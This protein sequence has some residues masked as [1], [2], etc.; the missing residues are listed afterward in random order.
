[1]QTR[2]T[3]GT[4]LGLRV[5]CLFCLFVCMSVR[6]FVCLSVCLFVCSLPFLGNDRPTRKLYQL[7]ANVTYMGARLCPPLAA[8]GAGMTS[9]LH[10]IVQAKRLQSVAFTQMTHWGVSTCQNGFDTYL[11]SVY[12][13]WPTKGQHW[14]GG[15]VYVCR[16]V[17]GRM[18]GMNPPAGIQQL[19]CK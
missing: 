7:W 11:H 12:S 6:L 2:R 19:F 15:D 3:G 10:I 1:M 14:T 16:V 9:C 5:P 8:C 4:V 17:Q 18:R 13:N